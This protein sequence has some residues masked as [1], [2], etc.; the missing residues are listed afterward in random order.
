MLRNESSRRGSWKPVNVSGESL[1]LF[2][3]L[4]INK[5]DLQQ[6]S[7]LSAMTVV[8]LR[9]STQSPSLARSLREFV[10]DGH[11]DVTYITNPLLR[12][13]ALF[14]NVRGTGKSGPG[15]VSATPGRFVVSE[16]ASFLLNRSCELWRESVKDVRPFQL[17][18]P[19]FIS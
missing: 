13:F 12:F 2:G 4:N 16:G 6:V 18:N 1:I 5:S 14:S 10:H 17:F 3:D 15:C 9:P 7:R 19:R 8:H 11:C